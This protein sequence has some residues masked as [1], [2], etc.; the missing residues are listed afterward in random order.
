MGCQAS[1]RGPPG[2]CGRGERLDRDSLAPVGGFFE[3]AQLAE[4]GGGDMAFELV[5]GIGLFRWKFDGNDIDVPLIERLVEIDLDET[6][7]DSIKVRPRSAGAV[8]DLRA[9]DAVGVQGVSLAHDAAR[10]AMAARRA[11]RTQMRALAA[12]WPLGPGSAAPMGR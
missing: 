2:N 6:D 10:R 8:V 7:G 4:M 3:L 1:A 9:F 5:W 11:A 12:Y